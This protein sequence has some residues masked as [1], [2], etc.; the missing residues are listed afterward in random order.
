MKYAI[1]IT[2]IIVI[3]C[4][5]G[6]A[7]AGGNVSGNVKYASGAICSHCKVEIESEGG[8]QSTT[9]NSHGDYSLPVR[10]CFVNRAY[11][12]DKL[13]W[14]GSKNACGGLRLDISAK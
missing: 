3:I 9:T 13:V 5:S 11:V 10:G 1:M 7:Y 12:S 8:W 4:Y 2:I 14:T 6:V